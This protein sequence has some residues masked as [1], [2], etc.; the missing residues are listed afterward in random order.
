MRPNF[1]GVWE[2][3]RGPSEFGFLPAP[4]LRIDTIRHEEPRLQVRTRQ[5]DVNGTIT[6]DREL[7][8]GGDAV[9]V[10]IHQRPRIVRGFWDDCA[11][12]IETRSEVSGNDRLIADRWTLDEDRNWMTIHRRLEQAGGPV[13]QRLRLRRVTGESES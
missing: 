5:K 12:V 8:I 7:M 11:L 1:S 2:L 6:V 3:I 4:R 13:H 10:V 9:T